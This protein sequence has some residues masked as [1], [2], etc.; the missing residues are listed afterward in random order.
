[1]YNSYLLNSQASQKS[2]KRLQYDI[3]NPGVFS[4][5][6]VHA[7]L[8]ND[9]QVCSMRG[10]RVYREWDGFLRMTCRYVV[11][12]GEGYIGSGMGFFE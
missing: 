3:V 2:Q 7:R 1:M 10:R 8:E 4:Y 9:M 6:S 12:E 5:V 11:C